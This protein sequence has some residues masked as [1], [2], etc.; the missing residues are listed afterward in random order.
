MVDPSPQSENESTDDSSSSG[1]ESEHESDTEV[2]SE[3]TEQP[4]TQIDTTPNA[5][6]HLVR[7]IDE[8]I[9]AYLTYKFT[10]TRTATAARKRPHSG[11]IPS[12]LVK[13][14]RLDTA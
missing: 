13:K 3:P 12:P 8:R 6:D 2:K 7:L 4:N 14:E 5:P 1:T 10:G 9:D 11:D